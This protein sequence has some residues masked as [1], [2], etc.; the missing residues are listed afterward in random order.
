[1]THPR[2]HKSHRVWCMSETRKSKLLFTIRVKR[3]YAMCKNTHTNHWYVSML[4][5][6]TESIAHWHTRTGMRTHIH[7]HKT[8]TQN[9]HTTHTTHTQHTHNTH[10]HVHTHATTPVIVLLWTGQIVARETARRNDRT[11]ESLLWEGAWQWF[12]GQVNRLFFLR[13]RTSTHTYLTYT[14]VFVNVI[15]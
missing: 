1:M 2:R 13:T 5:I 4:T 10:K 7:T 12:F 15:Y 14:H 3:G 9:T 6:Q 11:H 8:H